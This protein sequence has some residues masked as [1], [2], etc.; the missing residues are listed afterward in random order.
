MDQVATIARMRDTSMMLLLHVVV[1]AVVKDV[2]VSERFHI[3][4]PPTLWLKNDENI[5]LTSGQRFLI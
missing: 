2:A 4:K 1:P 3:A 5:I